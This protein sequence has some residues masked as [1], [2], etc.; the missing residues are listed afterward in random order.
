MT[1]N[2]YKQNKKKDLTKMTM[3]NR[4]NLE[5]KDQSKRSELVPVVITS[6]EER[7]KK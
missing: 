1:H 7:I 5:R 6:V 3:F 2:A 4:D